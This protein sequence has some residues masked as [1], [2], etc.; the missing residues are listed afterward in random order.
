MA[1]KETIQ[2]D[3]GYKFPLTNLWVDNLKDNNSDVELL[4][5][6]TG[7][8]F[9]TIQQILD[10]LE[11]IG[12][13]PIKHGKTRT[14]Y[15]NKPTEVVVVAPATFAILKTTQQLRQSAVFY[16]GRAHYSWEMLCSIEEYNETLQ[17]QRVR[18]ILPFW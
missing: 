12:Q 18:R 4:Q 9:E 1:Q 7:G 5:V 6:S 2:D 17:A 13:D 3:D 14:V 16:E 8:D 15:D 10:F 11:A